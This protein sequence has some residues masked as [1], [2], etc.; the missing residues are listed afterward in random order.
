MAGTAG[1]LTEAKVDASLSGDYRQLVQFI[2][3]L[4]RDKMFFLINGVTLTGQQVGTVGLRLRLTT[5]LRSP[6]GIESSE[7]TVGAAEDGRLVRVMTRGVGLMVLRSLLMREGGDDQADSG[8][9]EEG[10]VRLADLCCLRWGFCTTSCT[11]TAPAPVAAPVVVTAPVKAGP[12]AVK[13]GPA[14]AVAPGSVRRECRGCGGEECGDDVGAARSDAADGADAGDGVAGVF[15]EREEYL[16]DEFGAGGYSEA[17]CAGEA[18]GA[19]GAGCG[20]SDGTTATTADRSEVLRDG[21]CGEW[22]EERVSVAW[23]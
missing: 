4:E 17:C 14:V 15:G 10:C 21:D 12:A 19:G 23:G 1:E 3:S 22:V 6:V 2:N 8:P 16:F 13:T 7:K 9:T 18:E 20:S 5:Y 11:M